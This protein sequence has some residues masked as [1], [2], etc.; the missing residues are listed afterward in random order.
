MLIVGREFLTRVQKKSFIITTILTPLLIAGSMFISVKLTTTSGG[1]QKDTEVKI[2]DNTALVGVFISNSGSFKFEI[3]EPEPVEVLKAKYF[4]SD[5]T[6]IACVEGEKAS[7]PTGCT[8]YSKKPVSID[9]QRYVSSCINSTVEQIK[10][11]EYNIENLDKILADVHT[12]ISVKTIK[13]EKDETDRETNT[14]GAIGVSYAAGFIIYMFVL[15]FG[16]MVMR[17]VIEE[18][19]GRIIEILISSV[20]PFQLMS[21]KI[22]GIAMVGLVQFMM[23]IVLVVIFYYGFIQPFVG[24]AENSMISQFTAPISF[25]LFLPFLIYFVLGYFLYASMF[26]AVGSAVEAESET[27]Q[28]SLPITIPLVIALMIVMSHVIRYP[29]SELSFWTSIIPFTSPIV[30]IARIPFGVPTWQIILSISVL[31]LT[32][33]F[34]CY[35]A[36]RI[37]R[38]GILMYGKKASFK[39]LIKWF[40]YK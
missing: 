19:S 39:E 13:W 11:R 6:V 2:V 10:L 29:E 30:M 9:L 18:K 5:N 27:Q 4:A 14:F 3:I 22:I 31:V 40:T 32:F 15:M 37:Y 34:M 38:V 36:S 16:M 12:N 25:D 7:Y 28:L 17:G 26:A 35:V 1:E 33:V 23:W 21:G 20:R 24:E 8:F